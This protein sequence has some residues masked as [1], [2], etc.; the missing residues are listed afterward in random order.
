MNETASSIATSVAK[1]HKE[2]P[3]Q[4]IANI[5]QLFL[6]CKKITTNLL[7][8]QDKALP[9]HCKP[10]NN[11][12]RTLQNNTSLYCVPLRGSA[13]LVIKRLGMEISNSKQHIVWQT[14]NSKQ[15]RGA[16]SFHFLTTCSACFAKKQNTGR[17]CIFFLLFV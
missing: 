6:L 12:R 16:N 1:E 7:R 13:S 2:T 10:V 17:G 14:S 5:V 9:D 8:N 15:H 11:K 4:L 3:Q